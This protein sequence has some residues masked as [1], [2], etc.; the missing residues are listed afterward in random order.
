MYAVATRAVGH[1]LRAALGG[2]PVE[3]GIEADQ[4][5]VR[6]AELAGQAHVAVAAS[7]GVADMAAIHRATRI[8]VLEDLV[9]AVAIRAQ[10]RL[11]DAAR[12]RLA[13]HAGAELLHHLGVAH[14]AGIGHGGAER[15]RFRRQQFVRAAVAQRAIRRAFVAALARLPVD[16]LVVIARL[17]AVAGDAGGFGNV[18]RGAATLSCDSWQVSQVSPRMR[19]LGELRAPVRGTRCI[20]G[21][22]RQFAAAAQQKTARGQNRALSPGDNARFVMR[23]APDGVDCRRT[24]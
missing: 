23:H 13:V 19:A 17:V 5:V 24:V 10:R 11:G 14:A 1:G 15:L 20:P 22:R 2:Q 9:L 6:H 12:Q 21:G 7:A 8:G 3:G 4:P 16:A 18:R